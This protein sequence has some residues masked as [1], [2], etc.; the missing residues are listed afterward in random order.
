MFN[1]IRNT[2]LSV[3][4]FAEGTSIIKGNELRIKESDRLRAISNEFKN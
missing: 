3:S 4:C 1:I 2:I